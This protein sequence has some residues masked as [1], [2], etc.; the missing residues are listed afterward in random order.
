VPNST[1]SS[2][3][4]LPESLER[5]GEFSTEGISRRDR[6]LAGQSR[7]L[8]RYQARRLQC[9]GT[10]RAGEP[11]QYAMEPSKN[12]F[13]SGKEH[14]ANGAE[15]F[16]SGFHDASA[17]LCCDCAEAVVSGAGSKIPRNRDVLPDSDDLLRD[18]PVP[19]ISPT[20]LADS[21]W[22]SVTRFCTSIFQT[23]GFCRWS[24]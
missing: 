17:P 15:G 12:M 9:V 7:D 8:G 1:S 10:F 13:F 2:T 16:L 20:T 14:E 6:Q 3:F 5:S 24:M 23:H 21:T 4:S 22:P 19:R 18:V 11:S